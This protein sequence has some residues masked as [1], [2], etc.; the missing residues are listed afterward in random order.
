[1]RK[2]TAT[3]GEKWAQEDGAHDSSLIG[4]YVSAPLSR[5]ILEH[6]PTPR[7]GVLRG[8]QHRRC[9]EHAIGNLVGRDTAARAVLVGDLGRL[10]GVALRDLP[11]LA[12]GLVPLGEPSTCHLSGDAAP[13]DVVEHDEPAELVRQHVDCMFRRPDE[14]GVPTETSPANS[15][16]VTRPAGST[17]SDWTA[18]SMTVFCFMTLPIG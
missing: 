16:S 18:A 14:L 9:R 3:V 6:G 5:A 10:G 17:C 11:L 4:W 7:L 2:V 12:L 13:A 8:L 1:M 15:P